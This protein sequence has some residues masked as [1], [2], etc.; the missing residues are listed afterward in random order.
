MLQYRILN[1]RYTKIK[2]DNKKLI[3][4]NYKLSSENKHLKRLINKANKYFDLQEEKCMGMPKEAVRM[5]EI[6]N[7]YE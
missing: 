7:N 5:Y 2:E 4:E 1:E 6:I 3:K